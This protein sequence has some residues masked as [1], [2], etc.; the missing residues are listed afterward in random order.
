MSVSALTI[1]RGRE[2]H[3]LNQWKGWHQSEQ[4]PDRW[5][6]V[7]MDQD[8]EPP[9]SDGSIEVITSRV[10]GGGESLPLARARN[11]AAKLCDSEVMVFLDVDC[12]P[13]PTM[14]SHLTAAAVDEDRLWMGSPRYLPKNA[15][16]GDWSMQDLQSSAVKHPLQPKLTSAQRLASTEYEKFWSL[17]FAVR[18]ETFFRIGG[19]NESFAG[20]GGEDTDFAFAARSADVPFGFVGATAF[21]QHH[22]VCKPPLNHFDAI[23]R[24]AIQFHR[25]WDVWPMESWLNAFA[26]MRLIQ[27]DPTAA[28]MKV[29]AHPTKQQIA[30]A[31]KTTPAGF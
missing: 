6:I 27:F 28:K 5:I 19:F 20:Y 13:A 10:D 4:K 14:L 31:T 25:R 7:G 30:N 17:C 12:I 8:V 21:H 1:V 15:A 29:I 26:D 18:K 11:H 24:N 9:A 2:A 23:V 22:S 16:T 3:L